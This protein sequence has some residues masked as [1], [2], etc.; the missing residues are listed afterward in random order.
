MVA[1]ERAG[2]HPPLKPMNVHYYLKTTPLKDAQVSIGL[3]Q[4]SLF[5]G[6]TV[7]GD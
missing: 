1:K 6:K 4:V 2:R 3:K 7:C 5:A